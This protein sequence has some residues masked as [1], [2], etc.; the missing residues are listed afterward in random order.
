M[1]AFKPGHHRPTKLGMSRSHP[2]R[3]SDRAAAMSLRH[4]PIAPLV[5]QGP[6]YRVKNTVDGHERAL[7]EGQITPIDQQPERKEPAPPRS[8]RGVGKRRGRR[9]SPR[10]ELGLGKLQ[11]PTPARWTKELADASV[12]ASVRFAAPI[13]LSASRRGA[14]QRPAYWRAAPSMRDCRPTAVQRSIGSRK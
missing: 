13:S 2:K 4:R 14:G 7:L 9:P 1:T 6:H 10:P 11:K 8:I 3:P 5:G 12:A